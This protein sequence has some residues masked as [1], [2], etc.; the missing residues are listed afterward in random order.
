MSGKVRKF[1]AVPAVREFSG[2]SRSK[3]TAARASLL[4]MLA[5]TRA[6][7][8]PVNC[9]RISRRLQMKG[10]C[11]LQRNKLRW[12]AFLGFVSTQT[13]NSNL[14]L[15]AV[16]AINCEHSWHYTRNL[17]S[18]YCEG[19]IYFKPC[20]IANKQN[21]SILFGQS[22]SL[23]ERNHAFT[24]QSQI[25]EDFYCYSVQRTFIFWSI[26]VKEINYQTPW[27]ARFLLGLWNCIGLTA[28]LLPLASIVSFSQRPFD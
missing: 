14:L 22:F 7:I 5:N 16:D 8:L 28:C 25:W 3:F 1:C 9:S 24:L 17:S 27:Y 2:I 11:F 26:W 18:P 23:V 6:H 12:S 13:L 20:C 4:V 15:Y 21:M 10:S 19:F